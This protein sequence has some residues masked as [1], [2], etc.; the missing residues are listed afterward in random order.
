MRAEQSSDY[1]TS[2]T[3]DNAID[4]DDT[5]AAVT[6]QEAKSWLRLYFKRSSEVERVVIEKGR[7][8]ALPVSCLWSVS[9]YEGEVKTLCGMYNISHGDKFYNETVQCGGTI[10]LSHCLQ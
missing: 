8:K 1:S 9:V 3:A 6:K 2:H 10:D 5:T 4:N 7:S